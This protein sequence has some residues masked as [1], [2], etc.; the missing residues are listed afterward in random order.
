M[1]YL[2]ISERLPEFD[3]E[4]T[5]EL[6]EPEAKAVW[7]LYSKDDGFVEEF[8]FDDE[9]PKGI[10]IIRADSKKDAASKLLSLPLVRAGQ[11]KFNIYKM[12]PYRSLSMLMA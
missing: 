1:R 10:L 4:R 12:G 11:I 5:G 2:C 7:K 6:L 3:A 8:Y 9:T